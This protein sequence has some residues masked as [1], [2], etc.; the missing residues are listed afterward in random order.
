MTQLYFVR[1]SVPDLSIKDD[2]KRPLT[3]NGIDKANELV[4]IFDNIKIDCIFSSPY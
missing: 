3:K 4:G 1:H 2:L